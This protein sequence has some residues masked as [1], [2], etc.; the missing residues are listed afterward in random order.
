MLYTSDRVLENAIK[1]LSDLFGDIDFASESYTFSHTQYY[2]E[3]MGD[4]L[5]KKFIS[6]QQLVDPGELASQKRKTNDL[7]NLTRDQYGNRNLNLD[8]GHIARGRLI[9]ATTKDF[10]HRIYIGQQIYAEVTLQFKKNKVLTLPWTY[11]D[12]CQ[13]DYHSDFLA[14]REIYQNQ[15][16]DLS[17]FN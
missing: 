17:K 5:R 1:N 15:I 3:E 13:T 4:K 6:F 2:R 10:S 12:Y 7:E 11:P 9:L 14:I 16:I 8:P